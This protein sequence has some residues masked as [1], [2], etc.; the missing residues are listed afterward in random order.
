VSI[1][2]PRFS[3]AFPLCSEQIEVL[4]RVSSEDGSRKEINDAIRGEGSFRKAVQ[5]LRL[6]KEAG[7]RRVILR[8]TIT[9]ETIPEIQDFWK[10]ARRTGCDEIR[11][12]LPVFHGRIGESLMPGYEECRQVLECLKA[13]LDNRRIPFSFPV[14]AD[15]LLRHTAL[16]STFGC[17]AGQ[18]RGYLDSSGNF[19]PCSLLGENEMSAGSIRRKSLKEMWTTGE[20]FR[21]FRRFKGNELCSNCPDYRRCRGGCR[22]RAFLGSRDINSPD[23]WCPRLRDGHPAFDRWSAP[24]PIAPRAREYSRPDV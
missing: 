1:F 14:D 2:F 7:C 10:L 16:F 5:A 24:A 23:P 21:F 15:N 12:R 19:Y 17:S 11:F 4:G 20:S 18:V 6:L 3:T 8:V 22:Y 13:D 9:R